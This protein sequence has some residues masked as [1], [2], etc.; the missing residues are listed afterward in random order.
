MDMEMIVVMT[1]MLP[2]HSM[3]IVAP[4]G[5][6]KKGKKMIGNLFRCCNIGERVVTMYVVVVIVM[7]VTNGY[8]NVC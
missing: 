6:R 3:T 5:S 2:H 1:M 8:Y 4:H 7:M